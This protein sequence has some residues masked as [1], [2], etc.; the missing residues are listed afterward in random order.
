MSIKQTLTRAAFRSAVKVKKNSPHLMFVGGIVGVVGAAVLASRAT[1]KLERELEG[2][3]HDIEGIKHPTEHADR[4][5]HD[6]QKDL[7]Y[8]YVKGSANIV[9]M[10]APAIIVGGASI[11]MLTGSHI[12]LT[13][14]NTALTVAYTGLHEAYTQYRERVKDH[15]GED[16]ERDLYYGI[17]TEQIEGEDGKL[18]KVRTLDPNGLSVYARFFDEGSANWTPDPEI[19]RLFVQCQQNYANDLLQARGHIFLNEVY[20]MLGIDHSRAGAVVGWVI[21]DKGDNYVDFGLFDCSSSRFV[22]GWEQ[23]VLLDFNV[24]GIIFDKI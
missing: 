5:D 3:Q 16:T 6:C 23:S 15:V 14:R 11:A 22:N 8:A 9:K 10:Y 7:A 2:I 4:G 21:S 19:N 1:L 12:Q 13:R 17:K 24:D 18:K 20:D